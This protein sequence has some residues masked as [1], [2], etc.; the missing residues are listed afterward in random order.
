MLSVPGLGKLEYN[1]KH[2]MSYVAK[3][4]DK[5]EQLNMSAGKKTSKGSQLL[6]S[7][8]I[9]GLYNKPERFFPSHYK[10]LMCRSGFC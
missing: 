3:I 10:S 2:Y 8:S 6:T 5:V 1:L 7:P 9:V 4:Q